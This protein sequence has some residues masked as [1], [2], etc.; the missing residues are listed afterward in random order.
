[1]SPPFIW[2]KTVVDNF[3]RMKADRVSKEHLEVWRE[4]KAR[5]TRAY[6]I[7]SMG[8]PDARDELIKLGY[9]SDAL[10]VELLELS[11]AKRNAI[12]P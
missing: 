12:G 7:G 4:R 3:N 1:M 2:L 6:R 5:L 8:E 11:R 10:K 9:R